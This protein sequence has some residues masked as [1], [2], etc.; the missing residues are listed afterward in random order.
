MFQ[1]FFPLA[2][3]ALPA[4]SRLIG[5]GKTP[6]QLRR[7]I[8]SHWRMK[9]ASTPPGGPWNFTSSSFWMKAASGPVFWIWLG[10][11]SVA[12]PVPPAIAERPREALL[13]GSP[14][15]GL[16]LPFAGPAFGCPEK[17][18]QCSE[19]L[20]WLLARRP[21]G[22]RVLP[23]TWLRSVRKKMLDG[24]MLPHSPA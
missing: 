4:D 11:T 15:T 24:I 14:G 10:R 2:S 8:I 5:F 7:E 20:D 13:T 19:C 6:C 9:R 22:G 16:S 17:E 18:A 3:C 21:A 23:P 1:S 12:P